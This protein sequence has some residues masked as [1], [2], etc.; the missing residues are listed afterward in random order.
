MKLLD[1]FGQLGHKITSPSCL[2]DPN[3]IA[4]F[5][6]I[7]ACDLLKWAGEAV[8]LQEPEM[9]GDDLMAVTAELIKIYMRPTRE[10][11]VLCPAVVIGKRLAALHVRQNKIAFRNGVH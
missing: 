9:Q 6:S 2:E 7:V 8:R 5:Q 3:A 10:K 1:S 11:S 4:R